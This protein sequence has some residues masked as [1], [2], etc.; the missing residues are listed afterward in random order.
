MIGTAADQVV[1]LLSADWFSPY[2]RTMEL[3]VSPDFQSR[4]Q[5]ECRREVDEV[6]GAEEVYRQVSFAPERLRSTRTMIISALG[7]YAP[8]SDFNK[9]VNNLIRYDLEPHDA[10]FH[11]ASSLQMLNR[12]LTDEGLTRAGQ[13]ALDPQI[14]AKVGDILDEITER[15][16]KYDRWALDSVSAWDI[17]LRQLT[18]ERP[19]LLAGFLSDEIATRLEALKFLRRV[20]TQLL[21]DETAALMDW[22]AAA[23][24]RVVKAPFAM[25]SWMTEI[26]GVGA[27]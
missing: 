9:A 18:P 8:G 23:A 20:R 19:T 15:P 1:M 17:R 2:W 21:P 25:P 3:R 22:Y 4:L 24:P 27:R 7:R 13:R 16:V 5:G 10:A 12:E 14:Q 26:V 6:V 11:E